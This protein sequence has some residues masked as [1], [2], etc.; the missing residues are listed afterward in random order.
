[1]AVLQFIGNEHPNVLGQICCIGDSDCIY[2]V[3]PFCRGGDLYEHVQDLTGR[4]EEAQ[5]RRFFGQILS[6]LEHLQS[7]AVCHRD[8]SLE[9]LLVDEDLECV[10]IDMGMALR[11]PRDPDTNE[12]YLIPRQGCC[13]K[14]NYIS[15]E[16]YNNADPFDGLLVDIYAAGV[17][18]FILLVGFPPCE[19]ATRLDRKFN[20]IQMGRLGELLRHWRIPISEDAVDLLQHMLLADPTQRPTPAQIRAHPWMMMGEEDGDV[21]V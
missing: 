14:K 3:M 21:D 16:V 9:N 18:L 12:V 1:M 17:I 19:S 11:L 20:L 10:I 8:M 2:S 6:G 7:L 4:M 13:G 15:P 5:A